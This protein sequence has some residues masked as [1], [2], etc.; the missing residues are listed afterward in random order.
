MFRNCILMESS[1]TRISPTVLIYNNILTDSKNPD[2]PVSYI[3]FC[4]RF[5]RSRM[6]HYFPIW[7][8]LKQ[9]NPHETIHW[10]QQWL[11]TCSDRLLDPLFDLE[12][13]GGRL[14]VA[15]RPA[16]RLLSKEG[17]LAHMKAWKEDTVNTPSLFSVFLVVLDTCVSRDW[18]ETRSLRK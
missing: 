11:L 13:I 5:A 6:P 17:L 9:I 12:S 10:K 4:G 3:K 18:K 16:R 14:L 2:T 7:T 15:P 1:R 8:L